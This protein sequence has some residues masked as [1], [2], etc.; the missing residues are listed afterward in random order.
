M[1]VKN[2]RSAALLEGKKTYLSDRP[3]KLGHLSLRVTA[4]GTCMECRKIKARERYA[5]NPKKA[6]L[7]QQQR[8]QKNAETIKAKRRQKYAANPEKELI[9]SRVRST[10]W[11][12]ANPEKVKAQRPLKLAYKQRNP[13]KSIADVAKRRAAKL[14]RTP[15]WLT[16]DDLWIIDQAYELAALRTKMFNFSWHVDHIIPLQGKQ[17]SGLHVPNNLQIVPWIENLSKANKFNENARRA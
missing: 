15:S 1:P 14:Q 11:R 10:E 9:F 16:V 13:H 7:K 5:A 8:Y 12:A 6:I 3:C 2:A 4:T 17:V